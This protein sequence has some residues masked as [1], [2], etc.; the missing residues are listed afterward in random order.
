MN[1]TNV[2]THSRRDR[3][4]RTIAKNKKGFDFQERKKSFY[5][6]KK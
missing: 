6:L 4:Y 2:T 3:K 5:I 1:R